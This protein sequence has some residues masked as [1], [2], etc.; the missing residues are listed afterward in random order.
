MIC[1]AAHICSKT[2]GIPTP[3]RGQRAADGSLG[4]GGRNGLGRA[5]GGEQD[6]AEGPRGGCGG[7]G[8]TV[9]VRIRLCGNKT[10]VAVSAWSI[11]GLVP[12][13]GVPGDASVTSRRPAA[14]WEAPSRP[15]VVYALAVYCTVSRGMVSSLR[16]NGP[17]RICDARG[18][19][20]QHSAAIRP[21]ARRRSYE[22]MVSVS[23]RP[24]PKYQWTSGVAWR[25]IV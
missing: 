11:A 10:R 1:A 22:T 2:T 12:V 20:I 7:E 23:T 6:Q 19:A 5:G 8:T 24:I 3:I 4:T 17:A 25:I 18:G 15:P 13:P 21:D 14:R 9:D 16:K